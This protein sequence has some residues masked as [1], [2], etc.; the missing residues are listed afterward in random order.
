MKYVK[1]L[2]GDDQNMEKFPCPTCRS[3]FSLK[4]TQDVAGMVSN[5]FI[6]NMLEN[7]AIQQK[8]KASTACIRCQKP[9]INHCA[10]CEVFL[11]KKCSDSHDSWLVTMKQSNHNV[12]SVQEL[13]NPVSQVKIKR[14]LYCVKHEGEILKYYCE[15]CK[16]LCC[17]DCVVLNHQKPEHSCMA[18][19]GDAHKQRE[20]LQS[21]SAILD[22]KVSEGKNALKNVC[23]VMNALKRN[24]ETA[25]DQIEEQKQ[26]ILKIVTEKLC[27]KVKKMNKEIDKF[28]DK[29]YGELS[30]QHDEIKDYLDKLQALVPLP[31]NLLK[32]GSVEEILSLQK[33]IDENI[34]KLRS[35]QPENL[36]PVNDGCIQYVPGDIGNINVDEI[37]SIMGHIEG[38]YNYYHKI[39]VYFDPRISGI[40][41]PC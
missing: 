20:T 9:A 10:T 38:M 27:E 29:L 13:I 11:C 26:K 32:K 25:K 23:E 33:G 4:T 8:A 18:V 1:R 3:E 17:I 14:K 19:S 24:A 6:K 21:S 39:Y 35:K 28:Y 22:E 2:R 12:L 7:M 16:E 37:V 36:T 31:K 15:T 30:E 40:L 5:C 34:E 41:V